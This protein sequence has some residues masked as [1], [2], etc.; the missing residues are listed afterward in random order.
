MRTGQCDAACGYPDGTWRAWWVTKDPAAR[1]KL[2]RRYLPL[3]ARYV[4][5]F[6][7][8]WPAWIAAEDV[9]SEAYLAVVRAVDACHP[10]KK[11]G[12]EAYVYVAVRRAVNRYVWGEYCRGIRAAGA[13]PLAAM[14]D[15]VESLPPW[16][17]P[18]G[19]ATAAK[20]V[21]A[22]TAREV[23]RL[24]GLSFTHAARLRTEVLLRLEGN[25]NG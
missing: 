9:R 8:H 12:P 14:L 2:I 13:G 7:R 15:R 25:A 19:Q 24:T 17:T 22:T 20:W 21:R 11:Q 6:R 10:L 3:A 4:A 5:Q 23:A 18:A 1:E 16:R